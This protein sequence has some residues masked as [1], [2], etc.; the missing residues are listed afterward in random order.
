MDE[1]HELDGRKLVKLTSVDDAIQAQVLE[2]LLKDQGID[3]VLDIFDSAAYS[4]VFT[5]Q[6]G[7]ARIM[8]FKEDLDGAREVLRDFR[9]SDAVSES[10]AAPQD[11]DETV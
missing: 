1:K 3:C 5:I 11:A 6:K 9:E 10:P 4:K 2:G 7:H 8:V